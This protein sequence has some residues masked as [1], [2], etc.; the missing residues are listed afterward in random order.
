MR[1]GKVKPTQG[2]GSMD[3]GQRILRQSR[4]TKEPGVLCQ[5]R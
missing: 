4:Q 2:A 3:L 5:G 1:L